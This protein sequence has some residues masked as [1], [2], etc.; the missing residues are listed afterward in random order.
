MLKAEPG[1]VSI[2]YM[3]PIF[4]SFA[5]IESLNHTGQQSTIVKNLGCVRNESKDC[6]CCIFIMH[7]LSGYVPSLSLGFLTINM[8]KQSAACQGGCETSAAT[9]TMTAPT[10]WALSLCQVICLLTHTG[11]YHNFY[12]YSWICREGESNISSN[13]FQ[14]RYWT[15]TNCSP[16]KYRDT[17][18]LY[19]EFQ[20][21]VTTLAMSPYYQAITITK[22]VRL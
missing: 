17:I 9:K 14:T 2:H 22:S 10:L 19:L 1:I 21:I 6:F 18:S 15:I 13:D 12:Y 20:Y 4:I 3:L 16:R 7:I 5:F 8:H 11:S